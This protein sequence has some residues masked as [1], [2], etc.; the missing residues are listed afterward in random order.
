MRAQVG[1]YDPRA[2]CYPWSSADPALDD[3]ARRIQETIRREERRGAGRLEIFHQIW[4][5]AEAGPLGGP[6]AAGARDDS[7]SDR[8]LVLLSGA[9]RRA[10]S[11]YLNPDELVA[12]RARSP[13]SACSTDHVIGLAGEI[14]REAGIQP[15][16][17]RSRFQLE[18]VLQRVGRIGVC[19]RGW[20]RRKPRPL[21][22]MTADCQRSAWLTWR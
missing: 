10:V 6:A 1:P 9:N 4:D 5:L 14:R 15:G 13:G 19:R 16:A 21:R 12:A 17:I 22:S 7:L 3:L 11:S 20:R 8:T 2:L 18:V